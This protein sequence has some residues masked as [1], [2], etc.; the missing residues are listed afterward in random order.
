MN[1]RGERGS[2]GPERVAPS[3]AL[4]TAEQVAEL[5]G[6]RVDYVYELSRRGRIPT[7]TFGRTRRY[8]REAIEQWLAEIERGT[9]G[10]ANRNGRAARERPRPGTGE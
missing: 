2:I 5:I 3:H 6:M 1:D 4:L 8:R 9:M 7:I 10:G